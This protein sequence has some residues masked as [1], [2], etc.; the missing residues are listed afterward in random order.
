MNNI[1]LYCDFIQ[2]KEQL[3][4][5]SGIIS[6]KETRIAIIDAQSKI[7]KYGEQSIQSIS[8]DKMNNELAEKDKLILELPELDESAVELQ[9]IYDNLFVKIGDLRKDSTKTEYLEANIFYYR[10]VT[11]RTYTLDEIKDMLMISYQESRIKTV[12]SELT[13]LIT[14]ELRKRNKT[15]EVLEVY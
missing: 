11:K 5:I 9:K 2:T 1:E 10:N 4:K 8:N 12:S 14:E 13:K 3:G 6:K 15:K 7:S